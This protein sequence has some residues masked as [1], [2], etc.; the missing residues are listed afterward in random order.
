MGDPKLLTE[1]GAYA[2]TFV[3]S[4][5]WEGG[6]FAQMG[7]FL[8]VKGLQ[9]DLAWEDVAEGGQNGYVHKLPAQMTWPD[10][11][12]KRPIGTNQA[13]FDWILS[14]AGEGFETKS[15]KIQPATG[16]IDVRNREGNKLSSY[17]FYGA[18]PLRWI[19]PGFDAQSDEA[20]VE[21]LTISHHGFRIKKA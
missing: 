6:G 12:F 17:E 15:R 5:D 11:T 2:A 14:C 21:E 8:E 7:E 4:L 13:L 19:G 9:I 18:V 1:E 10:I 16:A 20:L 3:F